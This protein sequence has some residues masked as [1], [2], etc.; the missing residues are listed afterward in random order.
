MHFET[1]A[2]H[3]GRGID[4]SS[5]AVIP[6]IHLSTTFWRD[7]LSAPRPDYLYTREGNPNRV[8]LEQCLASLEGGSA[9]AA[10]ASGSAATLAV[11]QTLTTGDQ[12][13]LPKDVY[14]GTF[15]IAQGILARWGL[16]VERVDMT[17]LHQVTAALRPPTRL[18][19]IETPSNPM[20]K[21]TDIA[22]IAELAHRHG[23]RCVCDNTWATPLLQRPLELGADWVVHSTTK[24][25]NGHSDVLGGVVI[26]AAP[27]PESDPSWQTLRQIQSNGGAVPSPFECW[28][29]LRGLQTLPYRMGGHCQNA[30]KLAHFLQSHPAVEAVHYPGLPAHPA[31]ALAQTQ[32]KAFG[33]M[34]SFQVCGGRPEAVQVAARL[35]LFTHATSL[36]GPESLIEH[37]ASVEGP[38]SGTPENLLRVSVGLEHPEDLIADL[39]QGL[40]VLGSKPLL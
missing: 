1:L 4:P 32:M 15:K 31:H 33:G 13:L 7:P 10:F 26:T 28:L 17:D 3:A 9:A 5:G 34:L 29:T 36:G 12:V 2:I 39:A 24:Y 16:R 23:A 27:D 11:L 40:E 6:P 35:K 18:V 21:V 22:A 38:D 30:L 37:R 25:L 14:Y 20:L 19:W 8:A